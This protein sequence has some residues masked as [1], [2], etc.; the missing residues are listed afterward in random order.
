M[1]PMKPLFW[2]TLWARAAYGEHSQCKLIHEPE[3]WRVGV[4]DVVAS[5][6]S[7]PDYDL[8]KDGHVYEV[9]VSSSNFN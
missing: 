9:G 3:L 7:P 8:K 1:G 5:A 6:Q 2:I 4:K